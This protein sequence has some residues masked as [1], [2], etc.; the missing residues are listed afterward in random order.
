M[1]SGKA[2]KYPREVAPF[3]AIEENSPQ[4]I[5]DLARLMEPG[6]ATYVISEAPLLLPQLKCEGPQGVLQ[7]VY[8]QELPL[9]DAPGSDSVRIDPLTCADAEAMVELTGIAF[10]GFFRRRTC[11][12]GSYYGIRDSERLVAMC[13]ERMAIGGYRELSGLCTL[14]EFRGRGYA[15]VLMVRLMRDHRAAGLRSY[16][17][18]AANNTNAI[19]LYERMGFQHR[20]EFPIYRVT[21]EPE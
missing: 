1:R 6:E 21:R 17:H 9:P 15:P 19:A 8:P 4:A 13:G 10:P 7:M 18:V 5:E 2:L 3:A 14:P 12:M 20:G 16:L 11:E